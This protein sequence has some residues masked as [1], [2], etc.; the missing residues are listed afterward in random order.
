MISDQDVL[1]RSIN[2]TFQNFPTDAQPEISPGVWT[3]DGY[4]AP[5]CVDFHRYRANPDSW[6]YSAGESGSRGYYGLNQTASGSRLFYTPPTRTYQDM[7]VRAKFAPD[8]SA[9]QGFGSATDQF[10]EVYIKYDLK[11]M[12]G[13]ALRIQ[14][15]PA[16]EIEAIGYDGNGAVAGC[17][18]FLVEYVNGVITVISDK[19]MS[20]AFMPECT[21][22][23]TARAGRLL[24]SVTS[25]AK[26]R[27]GD[28]FDFPR[29]VHF[30]I[31]IVGNNHGGTGML[32]TGTVGSNSVLVTGWQASWD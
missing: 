17:A 26:S 13:Y 2:T 16:D 7:A 10:L 9:G 12:T 24:T 5:E 32:F 30:D 19:V 29:E 15:L 11:A 14:R 28:Q 22:K 27:S 21:V 4:L 20:S 18:F 8:K 31:P 1:D 3:L 25:T 6:T 23:L